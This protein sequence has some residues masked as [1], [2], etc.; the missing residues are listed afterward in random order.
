MRV[1]RE[2]E[3]EE[4]GG[5]QGGDVETVLEQGMMLI[6]KMLISKMRELDLDRNLIREPLY[7]ISKSRPKAYIL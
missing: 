1:D 6:S 7:L 4:G 3:G 5:R 2:E